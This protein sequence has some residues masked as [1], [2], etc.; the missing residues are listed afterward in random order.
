M[1]SKRSTTS[2]EL[3]YEPGKI[4]CVG[5]RLGR[6]RHF[7]AGEGVNVKRGILYATLCGSVHV[8]SSSSKSNEF[9]KSSLNVE[10]MSKVKDEN[11]RKPLIKII[12][13]KNANESVLSIGQ[14]V[15][16]RVLRISIQQ[17]AVE[18]VAY[19]Y[20]TFEVQNESST[21]ADELNKWR[22]MKYKPIGNVLSELL[23]SG[24]IRKEDIRSGASEDVDIY[25]SFRPGDI[26]LAKILSLGDS[27][28][29]FLTTSEAE[30][31]VI[32]AVCQSSGKAMA[33]ISWKEMECVQTQ[34]KEPRKVAKPV[35]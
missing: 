1:V 26:I 13:K 23:P 10:N 22:H 14:V 5:D 19:G 6:A 9:N 27:R 29:Y 33:P 11:S 16:C 18:I 34:V 7:T 32:R 35:S 25:K 21:H 8:G 2:S 17:V 4:V 31:G 3:K 12:S 28:R 30:L 24:I 20:S 15:L